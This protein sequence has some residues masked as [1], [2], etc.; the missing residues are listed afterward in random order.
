[1]EV[2]LSFQSAVVLPPST[3]TAT[4]VIFTL[5]NL[6]PFASPWEKIGFPSA[7]ALRQL[8]DFHMIFVGKEI[9]LL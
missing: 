9:S 3:P 8:F 1:M 2:F 4:K 5:L 6:N 7:E